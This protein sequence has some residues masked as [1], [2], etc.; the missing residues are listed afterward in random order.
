MVGKRS[1]VAKCIS[2]DCGLFPYRLG[3]VDKST[4]IKPMLKNEHIE[5]VSVSKRKN[6]YQSMANQFFFIF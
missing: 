1:E 3:R 2:T 4:E 5:P 6:E